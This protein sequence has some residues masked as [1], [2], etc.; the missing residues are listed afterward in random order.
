MTRQEVVASYWIHRHAV[1][2]TALREGLVLTT[3]ETLE[4][5]DRPLV[6]DQVEN[7]RRLVHGSESHRVVEVGFGA[8]ALADP[9]R[10]NPLFAL[11]TPSHPPPDFLRNLRS[12]VAG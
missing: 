7:H 4:G 5:G 11:D 1:P 10:G 3:C 12:Q 8:R 2:G 9:A 6:V